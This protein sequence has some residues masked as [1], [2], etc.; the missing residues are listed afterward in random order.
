M[1]VED[2]IGR[3]ASQ[4]VVDLKTGEVI[5]ECNQVLTREKLDEISRR[6]I[7]RFKLLFIEALGPSLRETLLND[8]I[9]NEA[10]KQVND[11]RAANPDDSTTNM[12]LNAKIDIYK[13][14][15]PGE[16]PT[17]VMANQNFEQLFFIPERYDLSKVGRLKINRKL[18]LD[19]PIEHTTL[20]K[21]D[22]MGVDGTSLA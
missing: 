12:T 21:E 3:I 16:P 14:L 7:K 19:A 1:E 20:R 10:A 8:R 18:G 9:G 4:D 17:V 5:L 11:Y 6:G 13:R 2:I 22:I 15:K